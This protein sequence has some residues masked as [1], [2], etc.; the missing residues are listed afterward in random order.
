MKR[1]GRTVLA[2]AILIVTAVSVGACGK[3]GELE[4]PEGRESEYP[5]TYPAR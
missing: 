4:L 5:R 3:R 2:M 1:G